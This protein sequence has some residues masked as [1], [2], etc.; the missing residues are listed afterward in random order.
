MIFFST[1]FIIILMS[2]IFYVQSFVCVPTNL[3]VVA[4]VTRTVGQHLPIFFQNDQTKYIVF[5]ILN[6][7]LH[8]NF[9]EKSRFVVFLHECKE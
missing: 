5:K 9:D 6:Y 4:R 7:F 1:I 3:V 8:T 2:N